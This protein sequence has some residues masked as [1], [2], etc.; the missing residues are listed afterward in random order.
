MPATQGPPMRDLRRIASGMMSSSACKER[1]SSN[2]AQARD[3]ER[4]PSRTSQFAADLA[5]RVPFA[6]RRGAGTGGPAGAADGGAGA[7]GDGD[8]GGAGAADI[9][10]EG[11]GPLAAGAGAGA[12]DGAVEDADG[13]A[14][15][16][17]GT[18][19]EGVR[20]AVASPGRRRIRSLT[21]E[22]ADD[23]ALSTRSKCPENSWPRETRPRR[24]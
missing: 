22:L 9:F 1:S 21:K 15:D 7:A 13:G 12:G 6:S 18:G 3:D 19:A 10:A 17:D 23:I 20:C 2:G 14:V 5:G 4:R 16:G 11:A 8:E 24:A